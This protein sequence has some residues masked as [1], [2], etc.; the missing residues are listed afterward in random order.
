[1]KQIK[2]IFYKIDFYEKFDREV[3]EALADGW[4]LKRREVIVPH[5]AD[6]YTLLYAELEKSTITE[7]ERCCENCAYCDN[8][9]HLPP[10][11]DCTDAS[12]WE[13]E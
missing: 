12:N 7:A 4:E 1:M 6:R 10:C 9:G 11:R 13:E 2:T 3:N 8:P 5:V